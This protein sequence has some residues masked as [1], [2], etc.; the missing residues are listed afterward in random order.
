M[1][2][3]H[4]DLATEERAQTIINIVLCAY[5]NFAISE[6]EKLR[7]NIATVLTAAEAEAARAERGAC[8]AIAREHQAPSVLRAILDRGQ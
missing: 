6:P 7:L 1:T 5:A 3:P 4:P 2:A 8:A